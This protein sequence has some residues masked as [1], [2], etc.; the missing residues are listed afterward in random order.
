M[1]CKN[2]SNLFKKLK[3]NKTDVIYHAVLIG[4]FNVLII[5]NKKLDIEGVILEGVRSDYYI[6]YASY[7]SFDKARIKMIKM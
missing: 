4:F 3:D 5:A 7:Q 6:A 1:R 2:P